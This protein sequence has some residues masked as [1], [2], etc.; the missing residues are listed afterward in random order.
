MVCG[1]V[2]VMSNVE[3]EGLGARSLQVAN[4]PLWTAKLSGANLP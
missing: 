3:A 1:H 4:K 2:N